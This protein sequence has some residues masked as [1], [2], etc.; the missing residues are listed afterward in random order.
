MQ[1]DL[2]AVCQVNMFDYEKVQT[3][4]PRPHLSCSLCKSMCHLEFCVFLCH[5]FIAK[6]DG[7]MTF[8]IHTDVTLAQRQVCCNCKSSNRG[9]VSDQLSSSPLMA[10]WSRSGKDQ[11]YAEDSCF[12]AAVCLLHPSSVRVIRTIQNRNKSAA[13]QDLLLY[14]TCHSHNYSRSVC[15]LTACEMFWCI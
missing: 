1:T 5:G 12:R 10:R 7:W 13:L 3:Q 4:L 2:F 15:L 9:L 11:Y 6:M 14:L 8:F